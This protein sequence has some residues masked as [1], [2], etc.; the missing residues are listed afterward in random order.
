MSNK[1]T[2]HKTTRKRP[3]YTREEVAEAV[4]TLLKYNP[5]EGI[6][7]VRHILLEYLQELFQPITCLRGIQVPEGDEDAEGEIMDCIVVT[8]DPE[9]AKDLSFIAEQYS[10]P[11][12]EPEVPEGSGSPIILPPGARR[13][14][15]AG[16]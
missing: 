14:S 6:P 9:L 4:K 10:T 8:N 7:I 1:T 16:E 2:K 11:E 12:A 13:D 15:E 3:K 5:E